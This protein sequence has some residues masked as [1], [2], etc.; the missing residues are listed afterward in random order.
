MDLDSEFVFIFTD[1]FKVFNHIRQVGRASE[2]NPLRSA[3][4]TGVEIDS[5]SRNRKFSEFDLPTVFVLKCFVIVIAIVAALGEVDHSDKI[6]LT[7]IHCRLL[8]APGPQPRGVADRQHDNCAGSADY[9]SEFS[10]WLTGRWHVDSNWLS[11]IS[12]TTE[13]DAD[14]E[15]ADIDLAVILNLG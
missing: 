13:A 3:P 2:N 8:R 15:I 9:Y 1:E 4:R 6:D 12:P 5:K 7:P 10:H 14:R 11:R